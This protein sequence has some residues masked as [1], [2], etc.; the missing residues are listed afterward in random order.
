MINALRS[1]Y[2]PP[3]WAFFTEV[4]SATGARARDDG[5][6]IADGLAVNLWPS[7]GWEAH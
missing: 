3:E 6:R 4:R 2:A 5:L 7:R 1:L